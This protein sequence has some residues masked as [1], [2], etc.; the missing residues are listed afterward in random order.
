MALFSQD[1]EE[2]TPQSAAPDFS[3]GPVE[4]DSEDATLSPVDSGAQQDT[5]QAAPVDDAAG[6]S[7]PVE[8]PETQGQDLAGFENDAENGAAQYA[9]Q[10]QS[11]TGM[12]NPN[13]PVPQPA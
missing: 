3:G 8:Q 4:P 5:P 6:Y 1:D 7:Q 9:V 11:V 13:G 2:E 10:G 12:N